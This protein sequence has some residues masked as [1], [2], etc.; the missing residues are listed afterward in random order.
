MTQLEFDID[1]LLKKQRGE[2]L[3]GAEKKK[4]SAL[5]DEWYAIEAAQY[6]GCLSCHI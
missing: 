2:G 6:G 5:Q 1:E 3:T 4:L